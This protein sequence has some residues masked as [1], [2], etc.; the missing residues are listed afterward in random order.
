[1]IDASL[2]GEIR[3]AEK[4]EGRYGD[5]GDLGERR[6]FFRKSSDELGDRVPFSFDDHAVGGIR[7]IAFE[8]EALGKS[9]HVGPEADALDNTF[10]YDV[11]AP[12]H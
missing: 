7:N 8:T 4:G 2:N 9:V 1:L 11:S 3:V 12:N 5:A 6:S 10:D